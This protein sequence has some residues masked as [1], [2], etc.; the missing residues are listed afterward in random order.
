MAHNPT[1]LH[2]LLWDNFT[3]LPLQIWI[4]ISQYYHQTPWLALLFHSQDIMVKI[5]VQRLAFVKCFVVFF[6]L[7]V[8]C[9]DIPQ[10]GCHFIPHPIQFTNH[11]TLQLTALVKKQ[12]KKKK[13]S[14]FSI[15]FYWRSWSCCY[16]GNDLYFY[17]DGIQSESGFITD[18]LD[19]VGLEPLNNNNIILTYI[20]WFCSLPTVKWW[21]KSLK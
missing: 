18:Y 2:G 20:L 13:K 10:I 8:K 1:G 9:H 12:N 21:D 7:S 19:L 4:C 17:L 11:P 14:A 15:H 5:L 6:S 16:S 3:F